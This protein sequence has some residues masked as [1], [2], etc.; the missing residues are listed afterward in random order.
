[1]ALLQTQARFLYSNDWGSLPELTNKN[2]EINSF[3]CQ[4]QA[5]SISSMLLALNSISKLPV[6]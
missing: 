4:S 3:S 1:M 6:N 2:G 5:W